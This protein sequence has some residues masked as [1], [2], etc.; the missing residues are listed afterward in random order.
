MRFTWNN[1]NTIYNFK[2]SILLA[3][4]L[5]P[6]SPS[7]ASKDFKFFRIWQR[8]RKCQKFQENF[9]R[10]LIQIEARQYFQFTRKWTMK[11]FSTGCIGDI[12]NFRFL[13]D[14]DW[15]V[16]SKIYLGKGVKTNFFNLTIIWVF[17]P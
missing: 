7:S 8:Q 13:L 14:L 11:C 9:D 15:L 2:E 12:A 6:S 16:D 17:I 10:K 5:I 1:F 4:H 3:A